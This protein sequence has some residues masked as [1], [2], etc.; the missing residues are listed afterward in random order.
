M[1]PLRSIRR[2]PRMAV[3]A[4]VVL[5]LLC[6]LPGAEALAA[7]LRPQIGE[8]NFRSYL[9]IVP[10]WQGD[11]KWDVVLLFGVANRELSFSEEDG[12]PV[13]ELSVSV[14]LTGR[15]GERISGEKTVIA[16]I[17]RLD[18]EDQAALYQV[19]PL[20]LPAVT[21][22]EGR[23]V[24]NLQ[25]EHRTRHG[26]MNILRKMHGQS[27]IELDWTAPEAPAA[28]LFV[29]DPFFLAQLPLA[30]WQR[31]DPLGG[32]LDDSRLLEFLHPNR[33]YGLEAEKLQVYC[34]VLPGAGASEDGTG[35]GPLLMQ[36]LGKDLEVAVR[37]T[38]RF[39]ERRRQRLSAGQRVGFF[40]ELDVNRLPPGGYQLSCVP[41]GGEGRGWVAEFDVIWSL[42]SLQRDPE[43]VRGEGM[44]VF[45]GQEL[46]EF[47][48]SSQAERDRMLTEFWARYDPDPGT[49][50]NEAYI[51][52]QRRVALVKDRLGGFGERGAEDDRGR[53]FLLLG[54][55]DEIQ[56]E[57]MPLN[58]SDLEDAT[59]RVYDRYA[60]ERHG[61]A[62]KGSDPAGT[63]SLS[64]NREGGI[65]LEYSRESRQEVLSRRREIGRDKSFELWRY[66]HQGRPL[67]PSPYSK[68]Q[69]GMR[70]LFVDRNGNG[71]YY[72][73]TTNVGRLGG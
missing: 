53:I 18:E 46:Q 19:F 62:S 54:P 13:G 59:A 38:I 12:S 17:D 22:K 3:V 24:C 25:D 63:Q 6:S 37:D 5:V 28:G 14:Q 34:E 64:P 35:G 43:E 11:Q 30:E 67:F 41:A 44:T 72:L 51:E 1:A 57:N 4:S 36:V 42:A 68:E 32:E 7:L 20:V 71:R 26:F 73:E 27:R 9:D 61:S 52:F 8:G 56:V 60:P 58:S 69:L 21:V 15:D 45:Y 2:S 29:G 33:R 55:P 10:R 31:E 50:I 47:L 70:F 65:P 66:D 39:D 48:N 49:R 16:Q 23:L 40:Y